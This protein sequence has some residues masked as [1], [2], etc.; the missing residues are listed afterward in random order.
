MLVRSPAVAGA[1]YPAD[2]EELKRLIEWSF[3]HKLGPGSLPE[4]SE[5]RRKESVGYLSPHAGYIY[6]GPI[7]AHSYWHIAREGKPD[8]IVIA[9][10]NHTGLGTLISIFPEGYWETPLGSVPVDA[11]MAK[12]IARESGIADLDTQAHLFEHSVE[13]QLPFLQYI[14]GEFKFVPIVMMGQEKH[15]AK[16][17]AEGIV[18]A[19]EK[20]GKDVLFIASSDLNHYDPHEITVQKDLLVLKHIKELDIDGMYEVI[21]KYDISV[22]GYG[23]IAVLMFLT[24]W[25]NGKMIIL[26]HATSGDTSG[27]KSQTVGYAAARGALTEQ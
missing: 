23:P 2:P 20:L 17:L 15:Q 6:S 21:Y 27:D 18:R 11:E 16:A 22:C 10:P 7:A 1:F 26:A 13:V 9:G 5:V 3:L 19:A 24:K 8:V 25:A 14:F 12:E 4:V